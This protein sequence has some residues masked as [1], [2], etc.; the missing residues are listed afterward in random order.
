MRFPSMFIFSQFQWDICRRHVDSYSF[1]LCE[2]IWLVK[3]QIVPV[4]FG[5]VHMYL[6]LIECQKVWLFFFFYLL[7]GIVLTR[8]CHSELLCIL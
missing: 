5:H 2:V 7:E 3:S 1:I 4:H 8:Y 6:I